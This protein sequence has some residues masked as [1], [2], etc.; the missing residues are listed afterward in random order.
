LR[1]FG[2]DASPYLAHSE[3][4]QMSDAN[5]ALVKS[6]YGCFERGEIANIISACVPDISWELVGRRSD[7]PTFGVFRGASG[8]QEFFAAVRDNLE[9]SQFS[10][11]EF[12]SDG[13]KVFVLGHY[14]MT[15]KRTG[16]PIQSDWIHVFSVKDGKV[17]RFR[18]FTDTAQAL[19]GQRG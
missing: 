17:A 7:F 1:R 8:M 4:V 11:L 13:D 2:D 9:F 3:E 12:Y 15:N 18:E 5:I 14:A 6:L 19:E 16:T 10:P